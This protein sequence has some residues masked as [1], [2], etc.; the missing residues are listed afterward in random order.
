[1][2]RI[3][4]TLCL[5]SL[6]ACTTGPGDDY[7]DVLPDDRLLVS[8]PADQ[9][10]AR[11]AA[12]DMSE[13]YAL[14]ADV[15]HDINTLISE[16]LTG[17][18]GI[19]DFEPTWSDD[20]ADTALWG[21]W[22]DGD[23]NARLWIQRHDDGSHSWALDAKP[24]TDG[25][26]GYVPIFAG[27]VDT[28]GDADTRSGRFAI[29]FTALYGVNPSGDDVL[30]AFYVEYD[31]DGSL[32][33]STA[34]FEDFAEDGGEAADAAYVYAQD[35]DGGSMDLALVADATGNAVP[36]THLVRTRWQTNGEGRADVYLTDGDLGPLVY[37]ATECWADDQ[38][39]VFFEEN[40]GLTTS[41]DMSIC[42][43]GEP[44]WNES[45]AAPVAI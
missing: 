3:L 16:V 24:L 10:G 4:T 17:I 42:A 27:E 21:P 29:D 25:D 40:Y 14:T 11:T 15:T 8:L 23:V 45:E 37:T 20:T 33:N 41:G 9:G 13:Y 1:M 6:G 19:T 2:N 38:S 26:D 36:E 7:R 30:G 12:G 18:G 28:G 35:G 32:V 39:V 34:V 22:E 5:I 31:I 43:F 44:E